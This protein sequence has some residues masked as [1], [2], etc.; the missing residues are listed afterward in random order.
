MLCLCPAPLSGKIQDLLL[1][2][3]LNSL[4]KLVL[5]NA[6]YFKGSWDKKFDENSTREVD[7]KVNKV[8]IIPCREI[9]DK[10]PCGTLMQH[11]K[12]F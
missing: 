11:I 7:F 8:P 12:S 6:I 9:L 4:T 10:L 5:V 2:G 3:V 1:P